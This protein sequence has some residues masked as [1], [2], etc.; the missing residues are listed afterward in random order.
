VEFIFSYSQGDFSHPLFVQSFWEFIQS[1]R[2]KRRKPPL[3]VTIRSE[4]CG[5]VEQEEQSYVK[6]TLFR[7]R[8]LVELEMDGRR[9][10]RLEINLICFVIV[11]FLKSHISLQNKKIYSIILTAYYPLFSLFFTWNQKRGY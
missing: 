8:V 6:M 2:L 3:W 5:L 1:M 7:E 11:L 10:D 9:K 4:R